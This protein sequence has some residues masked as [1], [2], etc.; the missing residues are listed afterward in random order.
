[1]TTLQALPSFSLLI[2][3]DDKAACDIITRMVGME[4]TGCTLYTADNGLKGLE[5]FK[6]HP[7]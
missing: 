2:V 3:E 4:F 5:L 1:M 7:P 6:E